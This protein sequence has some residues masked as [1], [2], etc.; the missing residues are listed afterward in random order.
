MN[1]VPKIG[2]L[3]PGKPIDALE[4]IPE[5]T[6][7]LSEAMFLQDWCK[8][9]GIDATYYN[10]QFEYAARD[11]NI[12]V[13]PNSWAGNIA[14]RTL[15]FF[16]TTDYIGSVETN[17]KDIIFINTPEAFLDFTDPIVFGAFLANS[18]K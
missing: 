11:A 8:K 3:G 15:M 16:G 10:H 13:A 2:I 5:I 6:Q 14:V 9:K 4:N 1:I 18:N 17:I 7:G 12:V